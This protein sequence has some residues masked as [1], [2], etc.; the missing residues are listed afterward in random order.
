MKT[1]DKPK[2][3][4]ILQSIRLSGLTVRQPIHYFCWID[5]ESPRNNPRRISMKQIEILMPVVRSI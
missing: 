2:Q 1:E 5:S 3:G 4:S